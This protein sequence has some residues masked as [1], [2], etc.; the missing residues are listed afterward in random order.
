[1]Q[2]GYLQSAMKLTRSPLLRVF[3]LITQSYQGLLK[4]TRQNIRSNILLFSFNFFLPRV[5]NANKKSIKGSTPF[6]KK[7]FM[8]VN[9]SLQI[10][11]LTIFNYCAESILKLNNQL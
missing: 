1:M 4:K 3:I 6:K 9:F 11:K 8:L 2:H 5:L 7:Y 10:V